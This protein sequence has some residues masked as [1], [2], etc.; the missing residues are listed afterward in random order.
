M[1]FKGFILFTR[2]LNIQLTLN[3]ALLS[4]YEPLP[5]V[6]QGFGSGEYLILVRCKYYGIRGVIVNTG[7]KKPTR[8]ARSTQ[9]Q[10]HYVLTRPHKHPRRACALSTAHTVRSVYS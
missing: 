7:Y 4:E 3:Q 9:L 10:C 6:A 5:L 8:Y 1:D 2:R